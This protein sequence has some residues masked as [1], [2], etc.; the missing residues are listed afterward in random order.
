M[1]I[2]PTAIRQKAFETA[3][4]GY[5]KKE[6]SQFLEE[7]SVAMEQINQEN[8]DLRSKLQQ[9]ESEAKR[10][11]DVEDSLFRTLKTA[12]D[13]GA[14]MITEASEAADQI[15]AEANAMAEETTSRANQYAEQT[16][17][18]ADKYAEQTTNEANQILQK[19]QKQ[20]EEQARIITSAAEAKAKETIKEIRESM[21]SLVRSYDGLLEQREALV[22]SLK[23]LSQDA[24]N[25]IDL[26]DAHF[27][28]IDGKAYQ[29]AIDEL[30]RSSHFSVANIAVLATQAEAP[31]NAEAEEQFE[32]DMSEAT[33]DEET[34]E[35]VEAMTHELE[36]QGEIPVEEIA[37]VSVDKT[38]EEEIEPVVDEVSE[39]PD[40]IE[41]E[42]VE[43]EVKKDEAI[44]KANSENKTGESKPEDLKKSSGS[45][46]DQ[47]D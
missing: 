10:L 20:A 46:F 25:Q 2:S 8:L 38:V 44:G 5:E 28:R 9:V 39:A 26:S 21:Q 27:F 36:E 19:A 17:S 24:L 15:I 7:M 16:I 42:M 11:K 43:E 12:E 41:E 35:T 45:F 31:T 29:R 37:E 14:T 3:F 13:T 4:R 34:M 18:Q 47:F 32:E 22:K 6:V 23:R 30:S 40:D 33:L 1:K